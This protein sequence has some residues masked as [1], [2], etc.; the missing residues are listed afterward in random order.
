MVV[1][2]LEQKAGFCNSIDDADVGENGGGRC[3][4]DGWYGVWKTIATVEQVK[5]SE[6]TL[7][8]QRRIA[9]WFND[10]ENEY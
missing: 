10:H 6:M 2:C 7:V 9:S 3:D 5:M 4:Y 1:R 8:L